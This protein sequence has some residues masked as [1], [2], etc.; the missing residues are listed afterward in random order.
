MTTVSGPSTAG[1]SSSVPGSGASPSPGGCTRADVEVTVIDA[2]NFHT[3]QPLLY[4]VATSGLDGES[5]AH[6]VRGIIRPRRGRRPNVTFRMARVVAVDVGA[7]QLELDDGGAV[8][9]RRRSCSA[10]AR[11]PTTTACRASSEHAFPL[12]H[13]DD[14]ARPA[15]PRAGAL[16]AGRRRPGADRRGALDVVVC[17]G[18]PTGVEMAGG[19]HELY[20]MVLAKDFPLPAGAA[21][22]G[23]CSS[24]WATACS[25][26]SPRRP[27]SGPERTLVRRGVEVLLG[28]GVSTVEPGAGAPDRRIVDPRR[29]GRLGDRGGRRARSRRPLGTPTGRRWPARRRGRP[30]AARP[31]RGVRHRRHRR[32]PGPDGAPLPQ[33]AQP[34]IQGGRHVARQIRPPAGRASRPSRSATT[35]RVRWRRSVAATP[36]PSCPTAGGSAARSAGWRGS[37]CTSCT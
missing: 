3:F 15:G 14:A 11:C 10:P 30:L 34:A 16:R 36:S 37:A 7:R 12:K 33:V 29:H 1:W 19:L 5:V 35:T 32:S 4:Q 18:G 20:D 26:R 13:V 21:T 24:R 9:V 23:S 2:N 22:P 17:G 27:R 31:P 8:A 6:A 25:P 28:V